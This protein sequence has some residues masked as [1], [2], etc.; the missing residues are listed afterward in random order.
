ME[1]NKVMFLLLLIII[2]YKQFDKNITKYLFSNDT[3]EI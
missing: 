1:H 3:C 2:K